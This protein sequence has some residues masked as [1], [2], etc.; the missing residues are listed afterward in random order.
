LRV[1]TKL[2]FKMTKYLKSIELIADYKTIGLG[3]GGYREDRQHF[4]T[5]AGI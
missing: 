3:Q 1:E 5:I 4:G 2:G